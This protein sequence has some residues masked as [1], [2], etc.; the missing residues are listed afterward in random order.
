[1]RYYVGLG[2]N[3]G[4]R[5][6]NLAEALL[7]MVRIPGLRLRRASS[8][9]ETEPV[10]ITD[11]PKFLN[12]VVE[13]EA[14]AHPEQLMVDLLAIERAM[15]RVRD[16]RWGPR[17]ID[18]DLLVW[19]GPP[20]VGDAVELPHPRLMERSFVLIPLAEIAPDLLLPDGRRAAE[21]APADPGVVLVGSLSA[22]VRSEVAG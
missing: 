8:V 2:A 9:Y 4:R 15:G 18:L 19:D 13:I 1:M 6:V 20:V 5:G 16:V 7:H 11:Q 3:L 17:L 14:D 12:M 21:A 10:G 22:V